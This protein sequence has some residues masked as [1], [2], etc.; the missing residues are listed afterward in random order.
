[1]S[2][3]EKSAKI[4]ALINRMKRSHPGWSFDQVWTQL[5]S[6]QPGLFEE[7]E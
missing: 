3:A 6:E 1:M 4:K 5:R 2:D 7:G